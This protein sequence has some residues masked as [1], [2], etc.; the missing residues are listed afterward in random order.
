MKKTIAAALAVAVLLLTAACSKNTGSVKLADEADSLAYIIGMNVGMNFYQ[1][2]GGKVNGKDMVFEF[3]GDDDVWVFID[4]VLVMDLG[5]IHGR[6]NGSINFASGAVD[7]A[8]SPTTLRDCFAAAYRERYPRATNTA[9]NEYLNSIFNTSGGFLNYSNH[10]LEFFY[11]ER[12]GGAANCRLKFN[13]PSLPKDGIT[14]S[15]VIDNYDTGAYTDVAFQFELYVDKNKDGIVADSEKVTSEDEKYKSYIVKE[16]GS[17]G[18]GESRELGSDGIFTLKH[19]EMATFSGFDVTTK[20][21]VKEVGVSYSEY[22]D[23]TI[24]SGVTDVTGDTNLANG[25]T[26]AYAETQT[27][28]VGT[29]L[30]VVFHNQCNPTNMKQLYIRKELVGTDTKQTDYTVQVM[31]GGQPYKGGYQIKSITGDTRTG[32]TTDGWITFGAGEVI[33]V[34]GNVTT[35]DGGTTG[36]PSGTTFSVKEGTLS[37]DYLEPSY[38][39]KTDTAEEP[40]TE[41]GASGKFV[42]SHNADVTVTNILKSTPDTPYIEV[43]KTFEGLDDPDEQL[44]GFQIEIYDEEP[45]NDGI[46]PVA[47]LTYSNASSGSD[48]FTYVWRLDDLGEGTYYIKESGETLAGYTLEVNGEEVESGTTI[49]IATETPKFEATS[50][51]QI[52]ENSQ[53]DFE[54]KNF[55]GAI[56]KDQSGFVWTKESLSL[57]EREAILALISKEATGNLGN[58]LTMENTKFYSTQDRLEHGIAC[59]GG[60]IYVE[61]GILKFSDKSLWQHVIAGYYTRTDAVNAEIEITNSYTPENKVIDLQKYGTDYSTGQLSGSKFSLYQGTKGTDSITW[62]QMEN[63]QE[64]AVSADNLSELSI[65]PGIY[66]LEETKAPSGYV[67]LSEPIYFEVTVQGVTLI[68]ADGSLYGV[69]DKKPDMWEIATDTDTIALKIKNEAL[70]SLPQS[71]GSGIFLYMI[72]GTLLLIAGSLM[73]YINRRK[74]VLEK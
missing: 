20:Y 19:N 37:N 67:K 26:D 28:S 38:S 48:G 44:S 6:L 3:S 15:K 31:A 49:T 55:I 21:K 71:G 72:G 8:G 63:Y 69:N 23:I 22:D 41:D 1:P 45:I 47:V 66:K 54:T 9:V 13:M 33:T 36:F 10:R 4:G 24:S 59:N 5:G 17:T 51:G 30:N 11:L 32:T 43:Q 68:K 61:N 42:L 60:T 57:G 46:E 2:A 53:F 64:I 18:S 27:L 62:S 58:K 29:D 34:L 65:Q 56:L 50:A 40:N 70:Y 35:E 39:I 14:V 74:G 52:N 12:G 16:L 7:N 73:I 25:E